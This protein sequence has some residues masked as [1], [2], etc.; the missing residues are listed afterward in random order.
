MFFYLKTGGGHLAP[1]KAVA[2][3]MEK[4]FGE[5]STVVLVDG[6]KEAPEY[7]RFILELKGIISKSKNKQTG[8]FYIYINKNNG[9]SYHTRLLFI[10]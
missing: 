7:S 9:S 10:F 2:H 3:Y 4:Y 6:L 8:M 5:D 1:A